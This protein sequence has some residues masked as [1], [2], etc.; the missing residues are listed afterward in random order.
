M[1]IQPGCGTRKVCL[2][3]ALSYSVKRLLQGSKFVIGVGTRPL[4]ATLTFLKVKAHQF[5]GGDNLLVRYAL[6]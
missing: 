3:V 6:L 1:E 4:R 5:A 2:E